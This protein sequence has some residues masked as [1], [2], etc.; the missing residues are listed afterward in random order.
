MQFSPTEVL[1]RKG[2]RELAKLKPYDWDYSGTWINPIT[3]QKHKW[4]ERDIRQ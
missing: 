4:S 2:L 3:N 1:R